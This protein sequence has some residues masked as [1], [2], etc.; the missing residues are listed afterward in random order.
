[1]NLK[2]RENL[3]ISFPQALKINLLMLIKNYLVINLVSIKNKKFIF[4][5]KF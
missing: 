5:Y 4:N 3:K 2:Y 1:M